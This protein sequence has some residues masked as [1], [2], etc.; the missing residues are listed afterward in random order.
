[1]SQMQPDDLITKTPLTTEHTNPI[2]NLKTQSLNTDSDI[3]PDAERVNNTN[4]SSKVRKYRGG[5][6]EQVKRG[7]CEVLIVPKKDR[8]AFGRR[9]RR[10][11]RVD[12]ILEV[13]KRM[14]LH[15]L[16]GFRFH[17]EDDPTR[18]HVS[19][20]KGWPTY[21]QLLYLNRKRPSTRVGATPDNRVWS[22]STPNL[23]PWEGLGERG[24]GAY[25]IDDQLADYL[26]TDANHMPI[27]E[28]EVNIA[29][30]SVTEF[31]GLG[32]CWVKLWGGD[33]T[34]KKCVG[35]KS[36]EEDA[37]DC[38]GKD[39]CN[40]NVC[41]GARKFGIES[42]WFFSDYECKC[43]V[44][45][46]PNTLECASVPDLVTYL[47]KAAIHRKGRRVAV[48]IT[49]TCGA[50][51]HI[52]EVTEVGALE[53]YEY[54]EDDHG[55]ATTLV[56]NDGELL[57]LSRS[58]VDCEDQRLWKLL[59]A[60]VE[61]QPHRA[62]V[63][64]NYLEFG[65]P[66]SPFDRARMTYTGV[67]ANRNNEAYTQPQMAAAAAEITRICPWGLPEQVQE[68][69]LQMAIPFSDSMALSHSHPIHAAIRNLECYYELPKMINTP[70]TTV[71]MKDTQVEKLHE[72]LMLLG[73]EY[74][75]IAINP[76]I[77]L[78]DLGRYSKDT[79]PEKVFSL[80]EVHTPTVVF[81]EAGQYMSEGFLPAFYRR[82]PDVRFVIVSHI[83]PL[84]R[85]IVNRSTRPHLYTWKD[86]PDGKMMTYIC[87]RDTSN[88]YTQ[89]VDPGLLMLNEIQTTDQKLRLR[90]GVVW[91][92]MNTHLQIWSPYHLEVPRAIPLLIP[93]F[94]PMPRP[95]RGMP[96]NYAPVRVDDYV[97][98]FKYAMVVPPKDE[99]LW[100]K[101]RLRAEQRGLDLPCADTT[102][103]IKVV[104]ANSKLRTFADLESKE[105]D[106]CLDY[107]CTR[108]WCCCGKV[109]KDHTSS[110]GGTSSQDSK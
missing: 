82:N 59:Q 37:H 104:I 7:K 40:H 46:I 80:P 4:T 66:I 58:F 2:V 34:T 79:I 65:A 10:C 23:E 96:N 60:L 31:G 55:K 15:V 47:R 106:G 75:H 69:A 1:M 93:D 32:T 107:L 52:H 76:I 62:E 70:Y 99:N 9:L 22:E 91:S 44:T 43:E 25:T 101:L 98:L 68:D 8:A 56:I 81:H 78:K 86:A 20:S 73:K 6:R 108:Q 50:R 95:F 110:M 28:S 19:F 18:M 85:L 13:V 109:E 35:C 89:Q 84:E 90:G 54:L 72:G 57:M 71:S 102:A 92:K 94:M 48:H 103:L 36:K 39:I 77:D 45:S 53:T 14:K 5:W 16:P 21:S 11:E 83:Y 26:A 51:F 41:Y 17:N 67:E 38:P 100:G 74:D 24:S 97:A 61:E 3:A 49:R 27:T 87:E 64:P 63:T 29:R 88:P 33:L 105:V 42:A 30:M 12:K